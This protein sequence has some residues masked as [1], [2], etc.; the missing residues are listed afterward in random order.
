MSRRSWLPARLTARRSVS[1]HAGAA[2]AVA[3]SVFLAPVAAFAAGTTGTISTFAGDPIGA[4]PAVETA[5][6]PAAIA[7]AP[8]AASLP[9]A[10]SLYVA[11][12]SVN[13]VREIGPTGQETV[14]AGNGFEGLSGEDGPATSAELEELTAVAVDPGGDLLIGESGYVQLVA[15]ANCSSD[16]PYGLHATTQGS[17]YPIAGDGQG[18]DQTGDSGDAATA[19]EVAPEALAVDAAGNVLIGEGPQVQLV[20]AADCSSDCPYGLAAMTAGDIYP[21]AGSG[22]YG[23]SGAGGPATA[24]DLGQLGGIALDS[25]GDLLIADTGANEV[26][27][28]AAADCSSSCPYGLPATVAGDIYTVAGNGTGGTS[29][30]GGPATAAELYGPEAVTVDAGDDLLIADTL[31]ARVQLVTPTGVISTIAAGGSSVADGE[32]ALDGG[33]DQP[34]GLAIDGAGDLL[35]GDSG[36]DLVRLVAYQT[37]LTDCAFGQSGL[38][39]GSIYTIAGDGATLF[40]GD[41]GPA[42]EAELHGPRDVAVD[43]AGDVAISDANNNRIRWIAAQDCSS[44]CPFGLASTTVGAIYTIAGG[45]TSLFPDTAVRA[46]S[47]LL[48]EPSG[49]LFDSAGDVLL[50]S[51]DFDV[52][53]VVAARNCYS[54]CPYGLSAMT[55]GDIY[56]IAGNS[57]GGYYGDGGPALKAELEF[58][59]GLAL[60]GEG[61]VLI[62]DDGNNRIRLVASKNCSSDCP[63]GLGAMT[64]GD[65]Y[66]IAGGGSE[67]SSATG[68]PATDAALSSPTGIALDASGNLVVGDEGDDLVR[69]I[70]A[71]SCSASCPYGLGAMTEGDIYTIAGNGS[72]GTFGGDGGPATSASLFYPTWV[73]LDSAGDVLVT[74]SV[75]LRVRIIAATDCASSCVDGLS[76]TTAGDIYT[77]AGDGS[78]GFS[79]DGG[80]AVDAALDWEGGGGGLAIDGAGNVLI[81][82]SGNDRIR[83]VGASVE[84]PVA[85]LSPSPVQF[86]DEVLGDT[87][88][89]QQ[90]T[91]TNSGGARLPLRISAVALTGTGAGAYKVTGDDCSGESVGAGATCTVTVTFAPASVGSDSASLSVT[92]N[93]AGS[94]QSVTLTGTA[95]A[96][97]PTLT[98]AMLSFGDGSN[99]AQTVT[100]TDPGPSPLSI[101]TPALTGAQDTAFEIGTD[102]CASVSLSSG[103]SCTISLT[104]TATSGGNTAT[105][106]I[107]DDAAGGVATVALEALPPP[108]FTTASPLLAVAAGSALDYTF[109]AQPASSYALAPGAPQWLKIDPTTGELTG[110]VPAGTTSFSYSVTATDAAGSATAGPFFVSSTSPVTVTGTVTG[111]LG[112]GIS[113]VVV[114]ACLSSGGLCFTATTTSSGAFA[115]DALPDTSMVLTAYPPAPRASTAT[116]PISIPATGLSGESLI[117]SNLD[118][119]ENLDLV[120]INGVKTPTLVTYDSTPASTT[121]CANGLAT[122]TTVGRSELNGGAFTDNV[123]LLAQTSPGTYS[124]ELPPEYPIHG[125]ARITSAVDCPPP[126]SAL[127]PSVGPANGGT[128]VTLT[129]SGFTGTTGV[130]F[131]STPASSF[132][133]LSDDAIQAVAPAGT[134]TVAVSVFGGSAPSGGTVVDQYTYQSVDSATPASGPA[135]GGTWVIVDGTGLSSATEVMFGPTAA[136][137]F[138]ALSETEL[139]ALSPPGTGAQNITVQT[140]F[141]GTTPASAADQFTYSSGAGAGVAK[142]SAG[143]AGRNAAGGPPAT[144]AA[145]SDTP[146]TAAMA[147]SITRVIDRRLR[148]QPLEFRLSTP[149][150]P[151]AAALVR[152]DGIPPGGGLATIAMQFVYQYAPQIYSKVN[153]IE[154]AADL[155]IADAYPT[156]ETNLNAL[157]AAI[158]LALTPYVDALV[159]AVLPEVLAAETASLFETGPAL[160]ALYAVTPLALNYVVNNIVSRLIT[161]AI[162]AALPECKKPPPPPKTPPPGGGGGDGGGE[163]GGS[164]NAY[165]D[166][167]GNVLDSNGNPISGA[168]VTILRSEAWAGPFAALDPSDPGILPA[169]N[170]ETTGSQG[171]FDWDVY[172]GYYEIQATAAT[173]TSAADPGEDTATIGPYPVPPPQLGLVVSMTCANEA[174]A[175]QPAVDSISTTGGPAAGGTPVTILG[176]GFTP[177]STVTFGGVPASDVTYESPQTLTAV[178]PA[179]SG[180][181]DV[182]VRS[183]GGS[184]D[185]SA[186]DKFY[187]GSPPTVTGL[188]VAQGP[189]AGGTVVTV[190]GT[191]FTGATVVG[192]GGVPGG[193]LDVESDT[194]LQVTAPAEQPG[195]VDIVV[196]TPAGG[197]EVGSADRFTFLAASTNPVGPGPVGPNPVSTNPVTTN[198]ST[199]LTATFDNA[200]VPPNCTLKPLSNTVLLAKRKPKKGHKSKASVGTLS[201]TATCSQAVSVK[202]TG[203][204]T[205]LVGKKPKYGTQ[206][207]RRFDLGPVSGALAAGVGK[208]LILKL[209]SSA[210]SGLKSKDNESV[211]LTIIATNA[212]GQGR[213]AASITSLKDGP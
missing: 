208:T 52:V 192:F 102:T 45:G 182:V 22:T 78:R 56:A 94:P 179:G 196:D 142:R 211:A 133:V 149:V 44:A 159:D 126:A 42:T 14:V 177:A 97:T 51:T 46:T 28:V 141:G 68:Y 160:L 61:D 47:V 93:A 64:E 197:S 77:I 15:A 7:V 82:D 183:A 75:H 125:P 67:G 21:V 157:A 166:P 111:Q 120:P 198:P 165:I 100:V 204:L 110:T 186:A 189:G 69:V 167:G 178:S 122:V 201:L 113:G 38:S 107:P 134:G 158:D 168:T 41:G 59:E 99:V 173:C 185:T 128:T 13:V 32:P 176:T 91:V 187:Y 24:A 151:K 180:M 209:P 195:T 129:G 153:T 116:D 163:G 119:L 4:G 205:E 87:P 193:A 154:D 86:G 155:A 136:P 109:A 138:Y 145:V 62:A 80:P 206:K 35:I 96:P 50:S 164:P 76:S 81:A 55:A 132:T 184:S 53:Q 152:P 30:D 26:Q 170:P 118:A 143:A 17:I 40:S 181:A 27:L 58:P 115:V 92:D 23:R 20:A 36:N 147:R 194:E 6:A 18:G 3:A 34:N 146:V 114:D 101:G 150:A 199:S 37:C 73:A 79:G 11:D 213:A 200:P 48:S 123:D 95:V 88:I 57:G 171:T 9:G 60:D 49:V 63:Y 175:P 65:I 16:C 71:Q 74:D 108:A 127:V 139:E 212:N 19:V 29:G 124:G 207:T 12:S 33:L 43:A 2:L 98:P 203:V 106:Q 130:D 191:G 202:L 90:V 83:R 140:R 190:H 172:S 161:A 148:G 210:I 156:C 10:T 72:P 89:A 144:G 39:S 54:A 169:V 1:C 66:T 104:T 25:A 188:S 131:G 174:P 162:Q 84:P 31:N 112:E 135:A 105:L 5:Q 85:T 137:S 70:A 103:K 117:V 8:N 121:G